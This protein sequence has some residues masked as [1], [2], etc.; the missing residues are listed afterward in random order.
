[1]DYQIVGDLT[2]GNVFWFL[3][4]IVIVA[5]VWGIVGRPRWNVWL[6]NQKG[7]ADLA[8][9]HQEGLASLARAKNEQQIQI[10]QAQSRLD[11][12]TL[13]K[14]A[15]IIEAEA[16]SEQ[17]KA[18]G[19]ELSRHDLFLRWQWIKMMD[20]GSA[21][22]EIIYVPTEANLPILEAGKRGSHEKSD[23]R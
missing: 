3:I 17:I 5:N 12:A 7:L 1:M 15:A 23:D 13:N 10:A 18:I 16:V 22:R 6:A 14:R 20:D 19:S 8:Q 21:D 2:I 11:A 4:A 9:A